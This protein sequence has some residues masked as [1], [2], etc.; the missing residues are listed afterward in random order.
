[1]AEALN[2][3]DSPRPPQGLER[4]PFPVRAHF[5][6]EVS[7]AVARSKASATE[8]PLQVSRVS[9]QAN[10]HVANRLAFLDRNHLAFLEQR[11][12]A[13]NSQLS[14]FEKR[15]STPESRMADYQAFLQQ[16]GIAFLQQQGIS[17]FSRSQ[18]NQADTI[19]LVKL[20]GLLC[21]QI[22]LGYLVQLS[23]NNVLWLPN[24]RSL[25]RIMFL[26]NTKTAPCHR[27]GQSW[28]PSVSTQFLN[29]MSGR[30]YP[31]ILPRNSGRSDNR[32]LPIGILVW[33]P[34]TFSSTRLILTAQIS[35]KG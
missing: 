15:T 32:H 3:M 6:A 5:E 31:N 17:N 20:I 33:H 13:T 9:V 1:M 12:V 4:D 2:Q 21:R 18:Q 24:S 26:D 23:P 27:P 28:Y 7:E 11:S 22:L 16:Q 25:Y 30:G 19:R 34:P 35:R 8:S 10:S 29:F 14:D